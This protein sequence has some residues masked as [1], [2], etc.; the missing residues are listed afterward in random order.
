MSVRRFRGS[1]TVVVIDED[2]EQRATVESMLVSRGFHVSTTGEAAEGLECV[3]RSGA[4]V[5]VVG[6]EKSAQTLDLIRRLR[7]RFEPIPLPVQPRILVTSRQ[8]DES[9]ERFA[10]KLGA[11]AFLRRPLSDG[12]CADV[13]SEL[14]RRPPVSQACATPAHEAV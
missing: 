5:V 7:G 13:V 8:L 3:R 1:T 2:P 12:R 9:I 6:L 10:R 4:D 11:D 14:A